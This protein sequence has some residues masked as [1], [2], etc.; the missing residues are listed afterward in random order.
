MSGTEAEALLSPEDDLAKKTEDV[1]AEAMLSLSLA[2]EAYE[3]FVND[4]SGLYRGLM[5]SWRNEAGAPEL[6]QYWSRADEALELLSELEETSVQNDDVGCTL[7]FDADVLFKCERDRFRFML[8]EYLRTR[9]LKIEGYAAYLSADEGRRARMS[10]AEQTFCAK[11]LELQEAL[12]AATL[13]DGLE[14]LPEPLVEADRL[15]AQP[16]PPQCRNVFAQFRST[17]YDLRLEEDLEPI[18]VDAGDLYVVAYNIVK[19]H[20]E[21]GDAVIV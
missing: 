3:G 12:V 14:G 10:A 16:Y 5:V 19:K 18:T 2:S 17:V 11:F 15:R 7:P 8:I 21:A 1:G 4:T 20:V 13:A 6:L 9:L